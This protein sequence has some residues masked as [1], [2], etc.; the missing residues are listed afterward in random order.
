MLRMPMELGLSGRPCTLACASFVCLFLNCI[1]YD[2]CQMGLT[3]LLE[4]HG[5]LWNLSRGLWEPLIYSQL[6]SDALR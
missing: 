4:F 2:I 1:L 5:P 6:T 3:C